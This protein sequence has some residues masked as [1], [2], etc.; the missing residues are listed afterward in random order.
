MFE[1]GKRI[2]VFQDEDFVEKG[3]WVWVLTLRSTSAIVTPK[4]I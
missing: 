4:K 1:V 2:E 3:D